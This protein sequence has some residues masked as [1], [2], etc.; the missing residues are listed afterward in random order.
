MLILLLSLQCKVMKIWNLPGS[1][2]WSSLYFF[3]AS[4]PYSQAEWNPNMSNANKS[5][6]VL[7]NHNRT[8]T[9]TGGGWNTIVLGNRPIFEGSHSFTFTVDH[10]PCAGSMIGLVSPNIES[11]MLSRGYYPGAGSSG[12]SQQ[13]SPQWNSLSWFSFV[14]IFWIFANFFLASWQANRIQRLSILETPLEWILPLWTT[15]WACNS[16]RMVR[17]GKADTRLKIQSLKE[18]SMW[19]HLFV[20][21]GTV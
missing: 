13:I 20:D 4:T 16:A 21:Q 17:L 9:N 14:R 8:V 11:Q 6:L 10:W 7:S 3:F 1:F 5:D 15:R 12:I 19:W 2:V 18:E